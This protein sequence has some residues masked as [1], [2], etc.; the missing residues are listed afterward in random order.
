M[1]KDASVEAPFTILRDTREK[2]PWGFKR[3]YTSVNGKHVHV[4]NQV[5][6]VHLETGDYSLSGFD[7]QILVE[8][9]SGVDL[10]ST[11]A[12][13][14]ARFV[15]ELERLSE[16]P[17]SLVLVEQ[18]W[19]WCQHYCATQTMMSPRAF[20]SSILAWQLRYPVKL[21]FRPT[22]ATAQKTCWKIFDLWWRKFREVE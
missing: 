9:K 21:I 1:G 11:V 8:R 22:R 18:E 7:N 13:H 2:K 3:I 6:T 15:R 4:R 12:Q 14:R 5:Q 10:V 17:Y 16:V 19:A 20:D